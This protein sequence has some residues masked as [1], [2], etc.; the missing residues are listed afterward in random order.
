MRWSQSPGTE[1]P[2]AA[3]VDERRTC[4]GL[5]ATLRG[6]EELIPTEHDDH[7]ALALCHAN[8]LAAEEDAAAASE[9]DDNDAESE[10]DGPEVEGEQCARRETKRTEDHTGRV[11][12]SLEALKRKS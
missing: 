12:H 11:A 1:R 4:G 6:L 8:F 3:D 5:G 10:S 2:L 7:A 9:D